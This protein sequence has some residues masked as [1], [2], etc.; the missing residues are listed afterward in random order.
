V[1]RLHQLID[2]GPLK[3]LTVR[4]YE[5][6]RNALQAAEQTGLSPH[7]FNQ[8]LVRYLIPAYRASDRGYAAAFV[9]VAIIALVGTGLTAFLVRRP[10]ASAGGT[11]ETARSE[12]NR[13]PSPI[14][15]CA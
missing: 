3:D 5:Q 6:L 8:S 10:A 7:H 9:A 11:G 14:Y 1:Q 15:S 2:T 4:Q 12:L 13:L